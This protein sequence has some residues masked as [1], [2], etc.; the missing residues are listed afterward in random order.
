MITNLLYFRRA[1]AGCSYRSGTRVSRIFDPA[2]TLPAYAMWTLKQPQSDCFC[3]P[4]LH[5]SCSLRICIRSYGYEPFRRETCIRRLDTASSQESQNCLFIY[6]LSSERPANSGE[7]ESPAD[8]KRVWW[9]CG[10]NLV[11]SGCDTSELAYCNTSI[12]FT[13]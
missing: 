12:Q 6:Y 4:S 3:T 2:S 9:K 7:E 5:C 8:L 11:T 13:K 1:F 10:R